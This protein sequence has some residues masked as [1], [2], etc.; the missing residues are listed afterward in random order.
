MRNPQYENQAPV[1]NNFEVFLKQGGEA[2]IHG[3]TLDQVAEMENYLL[4]E[5]E[6]RGLITFIHQKTSRH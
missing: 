1:I 4:Y 6:C 3:L 5:F 2:F